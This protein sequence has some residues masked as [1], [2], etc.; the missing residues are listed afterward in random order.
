M[1]LRYESRDER[2][3]SILPAMKRIDIAE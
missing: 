2:V 1:D 3:A